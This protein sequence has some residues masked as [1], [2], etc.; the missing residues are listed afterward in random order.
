MDWLCLPRFDSPSVFAAVLDDQKGGSFR[1]APIADDNIS[2]QCYWPDT[3]TLI[4]DFLSASGAGRLIDSCQWD[5]P[6]ATIGT[7]R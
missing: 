6:K 2:K 5:S 4:T 3:N 7:T 1:I